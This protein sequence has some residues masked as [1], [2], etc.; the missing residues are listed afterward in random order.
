MRFLKLTSWRE[1]PPREG[2]KKNSFNRQLGH[3]PIFKYVWCPFQFTLTLD[4]TQITQNNH[5]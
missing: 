1:G 3:V 5:A 2:Q 4:V